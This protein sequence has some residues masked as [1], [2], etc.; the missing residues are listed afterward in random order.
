MT[1]LDV[2]GGAG[3]FALPL[4]LRCRHVT[5]VEPSPSMGESL[6]QIATAAGITNISLVPQ[7]WEEAAVD[8]ADVVLSAHV[9]YMIEDICVFIEKLAAHARRKLLLLMFMHPP[10]ARYRPFW[11]CVHGEEKDELPGAGELMQVLWQM[12]IYPDL[13]MFESRPARAFKD[14]RDA[15]DTL[16]RRIHVRPDTPE[17][18]R[19][20]QCMRELLS[21]TPGGYTIKD[22]AAEHLALISWR[23]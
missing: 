17:D 19:L 7:R 16:R 4:A 15:L 3:R 2:G 14:W 10:L 8:A 22:A 18:L 1:V 5:V 23:P 6:Q 11:H 12:S 20:Q 13:E 9:V 21:E